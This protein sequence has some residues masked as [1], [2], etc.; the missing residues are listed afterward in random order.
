MFKNV[1]SN[2]FGSVNE[3]DGVE[4]VWL[5][6]KAAIHEAHKTLPELPRKQEAEWMLDELRNMPKKRK[7]LIFAFVKLNS[8]LVMAI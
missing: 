2:T 5:T 3:Q 8:I 7:M 4:P 6:A 1:L